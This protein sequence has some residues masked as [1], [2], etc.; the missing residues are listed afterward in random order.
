METPSL[1]LDL[2]E[3]QMLDMYKTMTHLTVV[4]RDCNVERDDGIDL[5][6]WLTL[7]LQQWYA[8]LL[9]SAPV[10]WLPVADVTAGVTLQQLDNGVVIAMLPQNCVRPVE[11][12]LDAWHCSVTDFLKPADP[13][14][15]LQNN[16]W[17]RG[18]VN[19]P[20][21][22]DHGD[23]LVLYSIPAD[24]TAS[25]AI[26]RCV[27]RPQNGHYIFHQDALATLPEIDH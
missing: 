7:R 9:M 8:H 19:N 12:R 22:I 1:F 15:A 21:A 11:W 6:D 13:I 24:G 3:S 4:R 14:I 20:A 10:E 5:D 23:H 18:G 16:P 2:T 26:A 27:I 17:T 25:L